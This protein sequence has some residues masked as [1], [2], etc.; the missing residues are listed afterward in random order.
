M[1]TTAPKRSAP[2]APKLLPWSGDEEAD[3]LIAT[4]PNALLIGFVLD[5]QITVQQAFLGPLI[6]RQRLGTLDP[7][8]LARMESERVGAA[9][10]KPPAVHRYPR[11]MA[12]RVQRL[13]AVLSEK[14]GG[15]ASAI[16]R[17]VADAA[18]LRRRLTE[19]PGFGAQKVTSVVSVLAKQ[20]GIHP[21]GWE[22]AIASHPTLA[23]VTTPEELAVYQT[24]KRA[25]KAELRAQGLLPRRQARRR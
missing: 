10:A 21:R 18:E 8:A 11:S 14:Y 24:A 23:D 6:I 7:N 16:W 9:F 13:C 15:D 25:H 4:D 1:A 22:S 12:E 3:R 17:D 20:F 5:Q 2:A 19:L